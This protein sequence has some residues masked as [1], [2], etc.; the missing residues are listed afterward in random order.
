M[1]HTTH[2]A[3]KYTCLHS[4]T[5]YKLSHPRNK[6]ATHG[7]T[8]TIPYTQY[9]THTIPYTYTH[10]DTHASKTPHRCMGR[11]GMARL[12]HAC[13]ALRHKHWHSY[14]CTH[15]HLQADSQTISLKDRPTATIGN[16]FHPCNHSNSKLK[17]TCV[18]STVPPATFFL[19]RNSATLGDGSLLSAAVPPA[20]RFGNSAKQL[21]AYS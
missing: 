16:F 18:S 12:G 5:R 21:R 11:R 3:H 17:N 1:P 8:H 20:C 19:A 2:A 7:T 13:R 6:N 9:H 4:L 10:M 14:A 15:V